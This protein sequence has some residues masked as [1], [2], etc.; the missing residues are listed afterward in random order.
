MKNLDK[1]HKIK[2]FHQDDSNDED[3]YILKSQNNSDESTLIVADVTVCL[4]LHNECSGKYVNSTGK[5][6]INCLCE[7]HKK[8]EGKNN[9]II[10]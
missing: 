8:I 6:I 5:Y 4:S 1:I 9:D 7:C 10:L 3:V 2:P